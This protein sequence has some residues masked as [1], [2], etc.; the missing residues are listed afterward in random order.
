MSTIWQHRDTSSEEAVAAVAFAEW[1]ELDHAL[2]LGFMADA[3][4]EGVKLIRNWE[5][6]NSGVPSYIEHSLIFL[7]TVTVLFKERRVLDGCTFGAFMISELKRRDIVFAFKDG[8]TTNAKQGGCDRGEHQCGF[9]RH[10][11]L[12]RPSQGLHQV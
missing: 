6:E 5:P 2:L 4:A 11:P 8:S 3:A 10:V 9:G 7:Q 12:G 1:L